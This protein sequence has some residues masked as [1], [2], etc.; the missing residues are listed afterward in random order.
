MSQRLV[1]EK[2]FS[3]ILELT[4]KKSLVKE[5]TNDDEYVTK[6][7]HCGGFFY[8]PYFFAAGKEKP[9]IVITSLGSTSLV[10]GFTASHSSTRQ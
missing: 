5:D 2:S 10:V 6:M 3:F 8:D 7:I 9:E 1:L 4:Q